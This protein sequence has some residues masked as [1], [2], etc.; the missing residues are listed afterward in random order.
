MRLVS[1]RKSS[2][3]QD[4]IAATSIPLLLRRSPSPIRHRH[5]HD[6]HDVFVA[7]TDRDE[8]RACQGTMPSRSST[9]VCTRFCRVPQVLLKISFLPSGETVG[10]VLP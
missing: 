3:L 6:L 4:N 8:F 9:Y 5:L 10:S 2:F 7:M 1:L